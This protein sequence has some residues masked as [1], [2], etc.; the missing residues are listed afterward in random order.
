MFHDGAHVDMAERVG[1]LVPHQFTHEDLHLRM[2]RARP[3]FHAVER[4]LPPRWQQRSGFANPLAGA[5]WRSIELESSREELSPAGR[6]C[7]YDRTRRLQQLEEPAARD[8]RR[9]LA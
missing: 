9:I 5:R 1:D 2:P 4:S 6:A 7:P 3:T 8:R